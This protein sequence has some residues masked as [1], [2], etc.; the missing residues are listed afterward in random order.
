MKLELSVNVSFALFLFLTHRVQSYVRV[1]AV[2]NEFVNLDES[3]NENEIRLVDGE[4]PKDGRVEVCK[5][6]LWG[7]VCDD[8]W[9]IRDAV[10]VCRQL[11]YDGGKSLW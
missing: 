7:S 3:C 2:K 4:T 8:G 11:G 9:D 6:G 5:G 1:V 10:V